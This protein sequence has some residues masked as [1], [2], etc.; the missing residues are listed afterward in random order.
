MLDV[1][2][3]NGMKI[4]LNIFLDRAMMERLIKLFKIKIE[5]NK[6]ISHMR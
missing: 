3:S 5:I 1:M 2:S 6:K 4:T